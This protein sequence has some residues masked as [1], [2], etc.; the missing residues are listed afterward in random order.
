MMLTDF[1][2]DFARLEFRFD[3]PKPLL[4]AKFFRKC[5]SEIKKGKKSRITMQN[6][7]LEEL[8]CYLLLDTSSSSFCAKDTFRLGVG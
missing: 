3:P 1:F 8:F 2:K 7:K 6:E 5:S 4:A